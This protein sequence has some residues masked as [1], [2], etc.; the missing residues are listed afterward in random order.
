ML[1]SCL[2]LHVPRVGAVFAATVSPAATPLANAG[3]PLS[4]RPSPTAIPPAAVNDAAVRDVV[5]RKAPRHAIVRAQILLDRARFSPGEIDA[6]YGTNMR[7]AIAAFQQARGIPPSGEVDD[8][9]WTALGADG[10]PA[11]V[12]Y[13]LTAEDVAGPFAPVPSSM[14][15][16][17]KL[18][19]L[20]YASLQEALGEKF[21]VSPELL[22]EL[23]YERAIANATSA[24]AGDEILV[25][26][27]GAG[28]TTD[29]REI[30]V[31]AGD[32]SVTVIAADG[33]V[34]ARYPATTGSIHD[35]LPLGTWRINGITR[36]PK[37]HYNPRL[38]WDAD[39]TERSAT[40]APGPNNPVGVVWIDLSKPHYGM[41]GTPEPS[42]IGHTQ[43]HGCIRLTN[44]SAQELSHMVKPGTPAILRE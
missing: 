11:L 9:T 36:A 5:R 6:T 43:S 39:A 40:I 34:F 16:K 27:V 13:V 30:V 4:P 31:S 14:I 20:H 18:E 29:A 26:N 33:S 7:H 10:A 1:A 35:P 41:H 19:A 12:P 25:P 21:H 38:F 15:E 24:R 44:W 23:N 3:G 42:L 2:A 17:E 8:A 32:R 37:F 22:V 28:A